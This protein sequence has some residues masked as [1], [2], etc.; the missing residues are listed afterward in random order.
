M[1]CR[2]RRWFYRIDAGRIG[3]NQLSRDWS[4]FEE[5]FQ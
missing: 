1:A 4:D 3:D 5:G 2:D